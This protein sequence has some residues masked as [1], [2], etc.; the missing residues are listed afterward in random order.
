MSAARDTTAYLHSSWPAASAALCCP[1]WSPAR[2]SLPRFKAPRLAPDSDWS[3][4]AEPPSRPKGDILDRV[5]E[6]RRQPGRWCD[7]SPPPYRRASRA[8]ELAFAGQRLDAV[9]A[10]DWGLVNDVVPPDELV[11]ARRSVALRIAQTPISAL[12]AT[13]RLLSAGQVTGYES[14]SRRSHIDRAAYVEHRCAAYVDAIVPR[15]SDG[16][17]HCVVVIRSV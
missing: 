9:T 6:T 3:L 5:V 7:T 10:R 14:V 17:P 2:S 11:R 8:A 16:V 1:S 12:R 13:K 4:N 15:P